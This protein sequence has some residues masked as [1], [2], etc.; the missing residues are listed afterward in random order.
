MATLLLC[1][2]CKDSGDV[3]LEPELAGYGYVVYC[4]ACSGGEYEVSHGWTKEQATEAWNEA[5]D[6]R[7]DDAEVTRDPC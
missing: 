6:M 7:M 3:R 5:V 1:H 4:N 2:R